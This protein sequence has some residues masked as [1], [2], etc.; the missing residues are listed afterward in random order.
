M[1]RRGLEADKDSSRTR[2][3]NKIIS[4]KRCR[5]IAQNS[6]CARGSVGPEHFCCRLFLIELKHQAANQQSISM[7]D[8]SRDSRKA[9]TSAGDSRF[10]PVN[11]AVG[12]VQRSDRLPH[13]NNE[14]PGS[15]GGNDYRRTP[16]AEFTERLPDLT[17]SDEIEH[18][19]RVSHQSPQSAGCHRSAV[20]RPANLQGVDTRWP[21]RGSTRPFPCGHPGTRVCKTC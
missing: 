12:R 8:W 15:A 11:S 16:G 18:P 1:S 2:A 3:V 17:T 13:P 19:P 9:G 20:R 21:D 6:A 4:E 10:A 14:L 7:N 5:G